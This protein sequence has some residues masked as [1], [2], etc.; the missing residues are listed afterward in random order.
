MTGPLTPARLRPRDLAEVGA[1]GLRA[2]PA[3]VVLSALGVALGIAT[4]VAVLGVSASGQERLRSELDR[5][6][7]DLLRVQPGRTLQGGEARLPVESVAMVR[8]IGPVRAVSATGEL[9]ATVRRTDRVPRAETGGLTVRA[10]SLNLLG[11]LDGRV[12][13][14]T[15]LNAATERYP[16]AVL[17]S[18]AARRLGGPRP[19]TP[20]WIGDRWFTVV[21]VLDP[22]PLA[23]EIE[24]AALVGFPAARAHLGFDGHPT[25]LYQRSA[26]ASVDAVRAVLP[27][28]V[29]PERPEEVEVSRP[30]DALAARAAAEGALTGLLL[31]LG[32]VAL[33]VG[34][35]GIA[36]TMV[37]SVLER[38]REIGLRR[39]LGATRGQIRA[40]FLAESLILSA[41]GG[42]AGVA[43]GALFTAGYALWRDWPPVVPGWAL[44]AAPAAA[45]GAGAL[46]GLYPAVR[47]AR[48]APTAAL[49]TP[50]G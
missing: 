36:N 14:G 39:A 11:T 27:R 15:W 26:E 22:L 29:N 13:S 32:A 1:A 8:R 9:P 3:R 4:M 17:G 48:L 2:R 47:A 28:T 21:G 12:R 40:Q 46:A 10:A 35:V 25:T 41:L 5:L 37:I 45:L 44:V 43:A 16:A 50:A 42:V 34:G 23:P 20:V 49:N 19:G 33:L 6:G 38:R 31:G 24:R 18:V 30:S 7:T